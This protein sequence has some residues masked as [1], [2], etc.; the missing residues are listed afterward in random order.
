MKDKKAFNELILAEKRNVDEENFDEAI[1]AS[2]RACRQYE[3]S[4]AIQSILHDEKTHHLSPQV[5]FLQ[6]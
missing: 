2:F 5:I 3:I 4:P 6:C 1:A